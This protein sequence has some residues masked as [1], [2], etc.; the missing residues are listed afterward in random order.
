MS[1][2]DEILKYTRNIGI[3]A[4]IDAGKTT[5]SERILFL[6]QQGKRGFWRLQQCCKHFQ[7]HF[8][9]YSALSKT[10]FR[11]KD[12]HFLSPN[13]HFVTWETN[14]SI[15]CNQDQSKYTSHKYPRV[16]S[17]ELSHCRE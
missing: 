11:D 10:S 3:M 6:L 5:T 17:H 12:P 9:R 1:K 4:H 2:A 14:I 8:G 13:P 7:K 15:E 16:F